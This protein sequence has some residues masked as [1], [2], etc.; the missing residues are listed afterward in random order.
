VRTW[1]WVRTPGAQGL[2]RKKPPDWRLSG[3]WCEP[4]LA[5]REPGFPGCL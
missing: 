5:I 2:K 1:A 3:G 4:E